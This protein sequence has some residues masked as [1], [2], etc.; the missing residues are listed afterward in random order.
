MLIQHIQAIPVPP[1]IRTGR[2]VPLDLERVI[3]RCLEKDPTRRPQTADD[4]VAELDRVVLEQPWDQTRARAWW[5]KHLEPTTGRA[6]A[7]RAGSRRRVRR[8]VLRRALPTALVV[9]AAAGTVATAGAPESLLA[10]YDLTAP[11]ADRWKLPKELN[12]ISGLAMEG[13]RLFAHGDEQAIVYELDPASHTV[14]RRFS[15]GQPAV[16]G[17]FE[18]IAVVHDRVFLTTSDGDLYAASI[19]ADGAAVP[20]QRFVTGIGR[21]CEVEGLAYDPKGR[22]FLFGCKTPRVRALHGRL[23]VIGWS[24]ERREAPVLRLGIPIAAVEGLDEEAVAP[25]ELLRDP[26]SGHLLFLA[27]RARV[28]V[29]VT[30]E[31]EVVAVA[32][33]RHSLHRQA[34]GLAIG[35]DGSLLVADEAAGEHPMLT[36]YAPRPASR[37]P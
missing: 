24:P 12:E 32:K 20:Y 7:P 4:L 37:S 14:V 35:A 25:S 15:L 36:R 31:G 3:M 9:T 29:E 28:I 34:E 21:S 18:A 2:P 8:C 26:S 23:A 10:R 17:D 22:E 1:S 27:A 30:P 16:R 33:L 6:P 19:G 5:Q 13:G 11:P